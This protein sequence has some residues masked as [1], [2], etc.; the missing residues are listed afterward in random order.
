MRSVFYPAILLAAP[1]LLSA[2]DAAPF[3]SA[4]PAVLDDD[5]PFQGEYAGLIL[6]DEDDCQC[7]SFRRV[8]L[9]VVALGGG[10]FDAV[11]YDFGLPGAGWNGAERR[12]LSGQ[13]DGDT[14]NLSGDGLTAQIHGNHVVLK[15]ERG[16]TL[17][18]FPR[19]VR[20]SPTLGKRPPSNA[21][22]LFDGTNADEFYN[23]KVTDGGLL[24]EGADFKR[25]FTDFTLHLEFRLPYMPSARGQKRANSGVYLQ[26][27]YEVQVLD[28]FGLDGKFNECGALYRYQPP[29]VNMCLPPLQWQT[30]DITFL[31]AR[32][33]A[34]DEKVRN[35]R[36]TVRHN[37]VLVHNC[38]DVERKTGAGRPES[39]DPYPIRLQ[40]HSDP[41]R[42]RNI[43]VIDHAPTRSDSSR[44]V[45]LK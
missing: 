2:Q 8:G 9:Q 20:K 6:P 31:S 35:A 30:Y 3:V 15:S 39:A 36:L 4:D 16:H 18:G 11:Y 24:M 12:R 43:W 14:A 38:F 37:G 1:A 33:K 29:N 45:V 41:V 44:Q 40:N 7:N 17:G 23:G 34:E 25:M 26:S 5:F 13:R 19:V 32:F 22:V 21:I 10:S 42:F 28:S 27:R